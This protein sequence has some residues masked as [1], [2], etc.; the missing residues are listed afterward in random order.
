MDERAIAET[1]GTHLAL[2]SPAAELWRKVAHG[3]LSADDAAA[4]VLA[5]RREVSDGE[6][7]ELD[8]A[9]LVFAPATEA[10]RG[11]MFED[12]LASWS[13]ADVVTLAE[14]RAD[15]P[16]GRGWIVGTTVV[17]TVLAA[18]LLLWVLPKD[19]EMFTGKYDLEFSG[20]A[21]GMRGSDPLPTRS[22]DFP[23]FTTTGVIHVELQPE[24]D[25]PGPLEVV[26]FARSESGEARPL[27]LAPVVH[28]SGK[29]DV[30]VPAST[31]GDVG[32]W[33]LVFAIGRP[34]DLPRS[35]DAL[36][37]GAARY[38]VRRGKVRVVSKP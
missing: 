34:D 37:D 9:K 4:A 23:I 38:V 1:L 12:L 32:V 2:S 27:S 20:M 33:E 31:L 29:V 13:A 17:V 18:M 21:A 15:A 36:D 24:D 19:P 8:R 14:R 6:R 16:R 28:P 25:V 30:E 5:G 26:V 3:E 22:G 11:A 7:E 35:W 10:R